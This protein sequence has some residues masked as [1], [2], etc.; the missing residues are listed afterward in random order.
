MSNPN[1][2]KKIFSAID[3][4]NQQD[5]TSV[6]YNGEMIAKEHLYAIRMSELLADFL[7]DA[8][9]YLQIACRAQHLQRWI[10]PRSDFPMTPIG[11]KSWRTTLA[12]HH[13]NA[14][15]GLMSECGY[16][17]Q[18]KDRVKAILQ[19][20]QLKQNEESQSMEDVACLVFLQFYLEAFA[21]KHSATKVIDIIRKTWKKMSSE[22]QQAALKINFLDSTSLLITTALQA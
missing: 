18:E 21:D 11:Y 6:E 8:S 16:S 7:P 19:K 9:E 5:P 17:D 12:K 3:Q 14:T 22:G 13:A 2:L 4:L 15:A 1:R 10:I 20:Q